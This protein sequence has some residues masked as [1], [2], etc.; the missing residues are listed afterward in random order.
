MNQI[1]RHIATGELPKQSPIDELVRVKW[2]RRAAVEECVPFHIRSSAVSWDGSHPL[3][4]SVRTI[5]AH[6]GLNHG[7]F[8]DNSVL[9][10]FLRIG[11]GTIALM[12]QTDLH[13]T[14]GV[15]R[16][17]QA[18]LGFRNRPGHRLLGVKVFSGRN[19]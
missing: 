9:D 5:A 19:D 2:L 4:F 18:I 16:G 6:P 13:Y 7:H 15:L 14:I 11:K 17:L 8:T 3:S 10:P 1:L 12:L